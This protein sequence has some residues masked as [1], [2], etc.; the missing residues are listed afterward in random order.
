MVKATHDSRGTFA[1]A[2]GAFAGEHAG[3]EIPSFISETADKSYN[4]RQ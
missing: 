3:R 2:Y 1:T 4:T